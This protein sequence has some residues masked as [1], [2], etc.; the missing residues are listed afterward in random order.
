MPILKMS[1]DDNIN[2]N[3]DNANISANN[4]NDNMK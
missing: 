1:I 3:I 4:K 2:A